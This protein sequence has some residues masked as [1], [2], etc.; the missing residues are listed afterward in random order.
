MKKISL[1]LSFTLCTYL[2]CSCVAVNN[3]NKTNVV[4]EEVCLPISQPLDFAY[5]SGVGGWYTILTLMPDG[6]FNGSFYDSEMGSVGEEYPN[7]T[8]YLSEFSGIFTNVNKIDE[9]SYSVTLEELN[10]DKPEREEWIEDGVLYIASNPYG[11]DGKDFVLYTPET[12]TEN[13]SQEFLS[14]KQ[15]AQKDVTKLSVYGLYNKSTG[16]GFFA[17]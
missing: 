2:L 4:I 1:L 14:W 13:L 7:G 8:V 11:L 10:I 3:T 12:P 9:Y 15:I 6:T 17:E 16:A 5:S